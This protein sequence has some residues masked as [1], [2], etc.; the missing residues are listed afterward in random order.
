MRVI[1]GTAK[2][3]RL[4]APKNKDTRPTL[5]RVRESLFNILAP[6]LNGARF[7]DLF[8]GTGAN[9]IE[10]LSRGASCCVYVDSDDRALDL[11][12]KNL[13]SARLEDRAEVRKTVLPAGLEWLG[14]SPKAYDII[15]ADPPYKYVQFKDLLES[16]WRLE[17][18]ALEGV[19]VI[20]HGVR[21]EILPPPSGYVSVRTETYGETGLTFFTRP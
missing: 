4:H 13:A 7:L 20:E 17:L 3:L 1:A 6:R 2:G 19:L 10:A 8:A 14:D 21:T 18:L 5:D 16:L 15:F 11:I 12:R 9:G